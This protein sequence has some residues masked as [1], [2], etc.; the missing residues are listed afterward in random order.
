MGQ[1]FVRLN[2][3]SIFRAAWESPELNNRVMYYFGLVQAHVFAILHVVYCKIVNSMPGKIVEMLYS[4]S[5]NSI[6]KELLC[7]RK[8]YTIKWLGKNYCI[9]TICVN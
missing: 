8:R 1:I 7:Q 6:L 9:N 2:M 5:A 4:I 3:V